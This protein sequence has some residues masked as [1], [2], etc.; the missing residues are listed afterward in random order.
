[1]P[2]VRELGNLLGLTS[3]AT[4]FNH[5][6]TLQNKGYITVNRKSRSIRVTAPRGSGGESTAAPLGGP[7]SGL[8]IIPLRAVSSA[9]P[10]VPLVGAIAAGKPFESYAE[11]FLPDGVGDDGFY[12]EEGSIPSSTVSAADSAAEAMAI[13][14]DPRLFAESGEIL[15]LRVQ[16]DSMVNAGILDGDYVL[17]RRQS[18]VEDGDIAAVI[19]NGEGTLKRWKTQSTGARKSVR[20]LP[21]NERFAPIEITEDEAKEVIIFG[22]YVGLVRGNLRML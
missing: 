17:I 16:G 12:R 19:I 6:R 22:K 7:F 13:A 1:M 4:V 10:G 18:T 5:L 20:L 9:T 8:K 11:G 15:A 3:T 14:I 2:T 21:A